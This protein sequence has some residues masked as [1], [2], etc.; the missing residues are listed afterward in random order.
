[1]SAAAH[2]H[3]MN[4][5]HQGTPTPDSEMLVRLRRRWNTKASSAFYDRESR[6][7][8][9]ACLRLL[10]VAEGAHQALELHPVELWFDFDARGHRGCPTCRTDGP[11]PTRTALLRPV[12]APT[13]WAT[14]P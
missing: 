3:A 14:S 13:S 8:A 1:M 12:P 9:R 2:R 4:D 5:K 11:C 7:E 6:E 10:A